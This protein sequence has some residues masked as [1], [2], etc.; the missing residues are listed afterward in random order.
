M[1][2]FLSAFFSHED[3]VTARKK[4]IAWQLFLTEQ[5]QRH[6]CTATH[7]KDTFGQINS[8]RRD[9]GES[10]KP[11][12]SGANTLNARDF[13]AALPSVRCTPDALFA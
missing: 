7:A 11:S 2:L 6:Y 9:H 8:I 4:G 12:T 3:E 13:R 1:T 10:K 5:S